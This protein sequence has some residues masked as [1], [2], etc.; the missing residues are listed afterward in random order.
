MTIQ[1]FLKIATAT[2]ERAGVPTARLD[3]LVL[4]EDTF[5][6]NR[7]W[8]LA[9]QEA[10]IPELT[11]VDLN[12]KI[13]QRASHIPLAYIRGKA[14]FYGREFVVN[15]NVLVPRPETE[16]MIDLLKRVAIV[17]DDEAIVD[18]GTGSGAIAITTKLEFPHATV[19]AT[20]IDPSAL[21]I[22]RQNAK[23]HNSDIAFLQGDLL[24]PLSSAAY[25]PTCILA[26]LP[27][28]PE[29]YVINQAAGHEPKHAIFGGKDG[30]NLYRRLWEQ[31]AGL[32]HQPK[33]VLTESLPLQHEEMTNLAQTASYRVTASE[34]FIQ[35]FVKN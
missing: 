2:L 5:G 17:R 4:L 35:L 31:V 9:H 29:R 24:E 22:A 7:A 18:V 11:E 6:H 32:T 16:G 27:Y 26:N 30:L 12:T 3:V 13:T 33:T 14:E 15:K 34:D 20:D 23:K 19:I 10:E 28:V 8:I 1:E 21:K 25:R